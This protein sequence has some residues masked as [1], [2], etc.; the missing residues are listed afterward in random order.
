MAASPGRYLLATLGVLHR[1][2]ISMLRKSVPFLVLLLA[3]WVATA[4]PVAAGGGNGSDQSANRLTVAVIG[5]VPYGTDQE[6]RF[7]ELINAIN[8]DPKVRIAA[9]VGDIKNGSTTCSDERFSAV[10]QAFETFKDPVIY[11]PGDNEWTDCHR[12]N[13]GAFNP[14]ERLDTLRSTFFAQP[15]T[16]L[17]RHPKRVDYQATMVENVRWVESRVAF[18]T[19]HVVGSNNG[20]APWSGLGQATPTADQLAEVDAR[21]TAALGWIDQTFDTAEAKG[22]EGVVLAMQADTWAPVP[23][24]GQQAIVDRIAERT[25]AFDGDVLLLQ[26]DSHVFTADNPL[27]LDNFTRIVVHGETLPFEYLRLTIDHHAN[28]LFSWERVSLPE[29]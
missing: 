5:D 19:L 21:I 15:G 25:A 27:G 20:L 29:G 11:T 7:D 22:L 13:N 8:D 4:G 16:A 6:A 12:A 23:G 2:V 28:D 9:H 24:S 17:G 18:A 26:G 10:A 1:I 14:L 3:P